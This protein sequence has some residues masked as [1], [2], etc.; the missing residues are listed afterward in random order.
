MSNN[1]RA[2][3]EIKRF[4]DSLAEA[5]APLEMELDGLSQ[6]MKRHHGTK[7]KDT[8][9]AVEFLRNNNIINLNWEHD[10]AWIT[11]GPQWGV[12]EPK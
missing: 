4:Y 2:F 11:P 9:Q 8:D 1:L 5:G 3:K 6:A 10:Q 12:W 7:V